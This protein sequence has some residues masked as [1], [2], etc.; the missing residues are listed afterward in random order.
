MSP[1]R[2]KRRKARFK[3]AIIILVC[4]IAVGTF[5]VTAF[6]Y[7]RALQEEELRESLIV[8]CQK[9]GNP[10]REVLQHRIEKEIKNDE[11]IE[12]L[13]TFLPDVPTEKLEE[14]AM[15]AVKELKQEETEI[16][17]KDCEKL[18]PK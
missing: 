17:P 14:L 9:N 6:L 8:N 2:R 15:K 18:Y 16:R 5:L 4:V 7:F 10:L 1:E 13:E 11:N 3:W 12:F